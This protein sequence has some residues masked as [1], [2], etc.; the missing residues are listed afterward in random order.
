MAY[1]AYL[2]IYEPVSAF[3]EPD[4]SRWAAYAASSTRP[5]RRDSLAVEHAEALRRAITTPW[6]A[7]PVR[8]S[9]H[10]YVRR[11]DGTT[12]VCPWQTR[13]RCLLA[14]GQMRSGSGTVLTGEGLAGER[15]AGEGLAGEGLAGEGLAGEGLA[16]DGDPA[17]A[18]LAR[19]EETGPARPHIMASSWTVP[20]TWFVPFAPAERWLSLGDDRGRAGTAA[21]ASATR[22]LVYTTPMTRARRRVARG[23]AAL[24]HLPAGSGDAVLEPSRAVGEL[25]EVGRWL[26]DFHPYSLVELDYGGLVHLVSDDALCGDQ[27]VAE[28]RAG[29]DGAA[30]GECEL[31]VAMYMRARDRWRAFAEFEQAN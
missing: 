10:A 6:V 23:L 3:H 8:E 20:L 31:A 4:R 13:L 5:R 9:E 14:Y 18:A 27:S 24:R 1:A 26:E 29:I 17:L 19:L 15:P 16:A 22:A 7:V 21:T 25:A 11:V 30:R 28:I 2:R 12:Y